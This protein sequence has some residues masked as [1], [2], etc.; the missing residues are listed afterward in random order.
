[1]VSRNI[2]P[3]KERLDKM[4]INELEGFRVSHNSYQSRPTL[5]P[6]GVTKDELLVK[7][8]KALE[9]AEKEIEQ[10]NKLIEV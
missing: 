10:L 9:E 8:H 4:S 5:L 2:F 6:I 1:M 3:I 7:Y